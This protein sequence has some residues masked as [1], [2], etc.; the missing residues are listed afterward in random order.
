MLVVGGTALLLTLLYLAIWEPMVKARNQRS[1]ALESSRQIAVRLEQAAAQ[2]QSAG[3]RRGGTAAGQ[4][5]SLISVVD[6]A[7]KQGS[8]GKPPSRIQPEGER[9]VRVWF[10]DIA[11]DAL[12]R[13]LGDLQTR[14]GV[15]VQTFD[16]EPGSAPGQ[17]NVRLSL[18]RGA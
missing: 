15:G 11:F 3:G 12:V 18:S 13:W 17:V 5:Q 9:T 8:L 14:Y 4:G 7:S 16:V 10:E 6:V 1:A 2:V